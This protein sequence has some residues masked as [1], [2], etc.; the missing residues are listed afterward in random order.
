MSLPDHSP[1]PPVRG[2]GPTADAGVGRLRVGTSGFAY[3]AWAPRFYPPG[4][5][6]AALLR[7]Y[8][9]RLDACELNNTFYRQ[10]S[11]NAVAT[12]LAATPESFRFAVKAQRGGSFRSIAVDTWVSVPWLTGPYAAFGSRLGSVL[13]RVPDPISRDD[14]R[15]AALLAAWPRD[16]PLTLEFQHASWHVDETFDALRGAGAVLCATEREDDD[17]PPTIRLTGPFLYLR[18]RRHAYADDALRHWADRVAPFLEAGHDVYAFFRHDESGES[19]LRA[20]ALR[21]LVDERVP[22]VR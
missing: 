15:L 6:P 22:A 10:P 8:G 14:A 7:A 4:L 12:W 21:D 1:R 9:A 19:P 13:F 17:D 11:P 16:V 3:P 2:L 18:L 20:I 5:R